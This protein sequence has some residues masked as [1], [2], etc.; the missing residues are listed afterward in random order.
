MTP[1][2]PDRTA[3]RVVDDRRRVAI[4][5]LGCGRNEVDS[6]QLAGLLGTD[7]DVTSDATDADVVLVNTCTFIEPAKQESVDTILAAADL[8]DPD[9]VE[10]GHDPARGVV[11]IGCMAQR[12]PEEL[13]ESLPEADAIVGFAGYPA[14]P[15]LVADILEGRDHER[16]VGVEPSTAPSV[17]PGRS[18]PM[19]SVDAAEPAATAVEAPDDGT[20]DADAAAGDASWLAAVPE[21]AGPA[22]GASVIDP[23]AVP[24]AA[25]VGLAT[26]DQAP[27]SGPLFPPRRRQDGPWAY[28]KIA[29]GCDR[30]CTF[31][32]I[33]SFRGRFR[34][35]GIG[36]LVAE[37]SWLADQGTRE[38]V[39]V[40]EN[41]TSWGK[42]LG[43]WRGHPGG[44]SLAPHLL[45]SLADVDG[46][47]RV[48]LVY[49][50]PA[51]LRPD[52][53]EAIVGIPEVA[54]YF[55]LSLQHVAS[56][57]LTRM[58]RS[59]SPDRFGALV[60][61]IRDLAPDAA[62][63]SNFILGFPGE[64]DG[65]VDQLAGFLDRHELD[66][67]G[68]FTYSDEDGTGA[69]ELDRH[70]PGEVAQSRRDRIADVVERASDRRAR[71][72]IGDDVDVI[73][74]RVDDGEVVGRSHREAPEADGEVVLVDTTGAPADVT[75]GDR[76]AARVVDSVGVDLVATPGTT[77]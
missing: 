25:T 54:N 12:Y 65:H 59:G 28:L 63:R 31:C 33:P 69:V 18:L 7:Y 48:R 64:D 24:P 5:T 58:A 76:V 11:V 6:D 44:R 37:A 57:V 36:E 74:E 27:A 51:E 22:D 4:V 41:T 62:I 72:R 68:L 23:L 42:D 55:D 34:S 46:I 39:L 10:P 50:Q 15:G 67:V 38:L 47:D 70:V 9:T 43:Q 75:V 3:S 40:S 17:L 60:E 13:S 2:A 1:V 61:R 21:A 20:A 19:V 29:S 8:K 32:A 71:A 35:R 52:L 77:G 14:L 56:D 49:L 30:L 26:A 73:V 53:L 16:V 66:F 45:Q